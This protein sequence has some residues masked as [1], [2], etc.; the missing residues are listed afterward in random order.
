[1]ATGNNKKY[2][3]A[4]LHA[5]SVTALLQETEGV[6]YLAGD[7]L[8][9]RHDTDVGL[10]FR[11]ESN[12][13]YLTGVNE[14]SFHYLFDIKSQKSVLIA[15]PINPALVVWMG[16]PPTLEELAATYDVDEVVYL[17]EAAKTLKDFSPSLIYTLPGVSL[18]SEW[19]STTKTEDTRLIKAIH[20]ARTIKDTFE[21]SQMKKANEISGQAHQ[22]LMKAVKTGM[23]ERELDALFRYTCHRLGGT[24]QAYN[25]IVAVGKNAAT[26]HYG[27]NDQPIKSEEQLLL[28]DAACEYEL[29]AADITRTYPV[30][31]KFTPEAADIYG[32]VL[33]IQKTIIDEIKP[34]AHWEDLHRRALQILVQGL[35][36]LGIF[37][38]SEEDIIAAKTATA[39]LPHGLGHFIGL[40][41]HDVNGLPDGKSQEVD[42]KYLRLRRALEENM[43][44]TVEPGLYFCDFIIE[45]Y[46]ESETHSKFIN[47]EVLDKYRPVGGVRIEDC[48]LVT[49]D[50]SQ[51]LTNVP[52][53]ITDVESL[54]KAS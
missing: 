38:G 2:P 41:V 47:K 39:F 31:G 23:N 1:M 43:I 29:Y 9:E 37:K 26:L 16:L 3:N 36:E 8:H 49:K 7:V 10:L 54:M 27:R 42:L 4:K 22:E 32:L 18:P 35:L 30:G 51:N 12:F 50:G 45:P 15:P 28:V 44:V 52:K 20:E 19:A 48:I 5:L 11:Q 53:E 46:L 14:P 6:I 33:K 21:I 40:D 24:F 13:F 17:A 25:P 34:S